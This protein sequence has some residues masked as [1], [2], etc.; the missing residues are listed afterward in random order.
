MKK[1]FY[2]S[3]V[4]LLP[5]GLVAQTGDNSQLFI[6]DML[7]LAK[8]FAQPA[9][10]GAS[11]QASAGWFSSAT[12]L[13]KWDLRIA[14]HGNAL[15]VPNDKKS[16]N[17]SNSDLELLEMEGVTSASFPTAFGASTSD[18]FVGDVTFENPLTGG[19]LTESVRFK[20]IDGINRDYVP[21]AFVQASV[22]V[23]AGTEITVRA[24]PEVAIDGVTAST[25][26]IG[27]KHSLSQ[28]FNNVY[29]EDFQLAFGAAYSVLNVDYEFEPISVQNFLTMNHIVVDANLFLAEIIGSKRWS[30]FEVFAAAG[31][32]NSSFDYEM[33][34][35]GIALPRVNEELGEIEGGQ[36]QFKGDLGLNLYFSRFRLNAM[37]SAGDF[38]NANIGLAVGI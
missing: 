24:M 9:A 21:H 2:L 7:V 20:G 35:D 33:G 17:L 34:G 30:Y 10:D 27:A 15:F 6:N 1:L 32:M 3:L 23:S 18:Y 19:V 13:E 37:L 29:P 26:G 36:T 38:F 25:Y 8:N 28:Y 16:F 22:G 12:A 5:S 11:Y 14:V 4:F 31:I